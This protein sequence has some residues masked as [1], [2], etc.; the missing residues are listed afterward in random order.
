MKDYQP[1]PEAA[2][3]PVYTFHDDGRGG[4]GFS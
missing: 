1:V 2:E 4:G 3:E